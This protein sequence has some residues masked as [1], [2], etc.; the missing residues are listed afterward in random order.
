MTLG[1]AS[2]A[3]TDV[4]YG[5][6]LAVSEDRATKALLVLKATLAVLETWPTIARAHRQS[7]SACPEVE[8]LGPRGAPIPHG[9]TALALLP[10][11]LRLWP[12][13]P[14]PDSEVAA[15]A[16]SGAELLSLPHV[17]E[18]LAARAL[19]TIDAKKV[20]GTRLRRLPPADTRGVCWRVAGGETEPGAVAKIEARAALRP[21]VAALPGVSTLTLQAH[22]LSLRV[23]RYVETMAAKITA[24]R[25]EGFVALGKTERVGVLVEED[26]EEVTLLLE[27]VVSRDL[28]DISLGL[29]QVHG[30]EPC[31]NTAS[32]AAL[33]EGAAVHV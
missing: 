30:A 13:D 6:A 8:T 7:L 9:I 12:A 10:A 26:T 17:T 32:P 15:S 5:I 24:G 27:V 20:G 22:R 33:A 14:C 23:D 19:R 11:L 21:S 25:G 2:E 4:L 3:Q 18:G 29:T 28:A 31:W 16:V 1:E